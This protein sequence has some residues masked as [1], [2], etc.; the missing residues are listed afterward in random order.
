MRH[1]PNFLRTCTIVMLCIGAVS[2][3]KDNVALEDEDTPIL[4]QRNIKNLIPSRVRDRD[5]WANDIYSIMDTLQVE[6]NKTNV[7]SILAIVDQESNFV[8]NP[9]VPNLGEKA[10]KEVNHRLEGK[11]ADKLGD[12]L[13]E[14]VAKYFLNVLK[15]Q[16]SAENNYLAQMRKVKTEKDLDILYREI[17]NYMTKHYHVSAITGAAKLLGQDIGERMNP[18]TTL[19]SMQVLINYA[20]DHQRSRM[21]IYE[22]RDDLYTQYGGLYYGIHRLMLYQ[23]NYSK[24]LYR[25]ADYNSGIYSSRN[26]SFQQAL[27][28]LT[29]MTLSLDGDLL[30]YDKN[31]NVLSDRSQSELA[32]QHLFT[33][34]AIQLS[35]KQI[36]SDLKQEKTVDFE[37]TQTY[38]EVQILYKQKFGRALVYAIMPEVVISGP[39][40]S[41]NYNTNWYASKV[42]NRYLSCMQRTRSGR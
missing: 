26:A 40:L 3:T 25:F 5:S 23:A 16:P 20:Q 36:R 39:K 34:H 17:F 41:K 13:G 28:K 7:C 4:T 24:P 1:Y 42:N 10:V 12:R 29:K 19:G 31:E 38:K 27:T 35:P 18:I 2:C 14:P 21:N 33:E 37:K 8:A 15:T 22:L 9:Q 11:F 32:I 30:L 6:K